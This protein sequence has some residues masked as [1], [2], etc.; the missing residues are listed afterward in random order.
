MIVVKNKR[1][2]KVL[3]NQRIEEQGPNCDLNDIDVSG[4]TDM[5]FL[6]YGTN[7]NGNISLW[8]VSKVMFMDGMFA[9][10]E[11]NGDISNWNVSNVINM[12][13]MFY[14]SPLDGKEPRWYRG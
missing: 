3:I 7:F 1:E 10:S 8:N 4:I 5:S 12:S 9:W 2:L 13:K 14:K 6:F 11:F